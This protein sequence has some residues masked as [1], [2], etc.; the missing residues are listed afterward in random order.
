M[1]RVQI[2][3][4]L[5]SVCCYA[6]TAKSKAPAA[7]S[8]AL[9]SCE[10]SLAE[11]QK[12]S[13]DVAAESS[14]TLAAANRWQ[15]KYEDAMT[16]LTLLQ[17]EVSGKTVSDEQTDRLSKVSGGEALDSAI[18][19]EKNHNQLIEIAR[20]VIEHDSMATNK[21]NALLADYK[22]YVDRVGIQLAQ[23]RQQNRVSNALALYNLMPKYQP[24][25]TFNV[26]VT[27]CTKLPA[28]C[29]H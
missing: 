17:T 5:L 25:Q 15:K 9:V 21:Y 12:F 16:L 4:L 20:Q 29:V 11:T 22:D 27:D 8:K 14:S 26:N 1:R 6:Q 7:K 28:L 10:N 2:A 19:I 18:A 13:E 24:P 23:M 3:M